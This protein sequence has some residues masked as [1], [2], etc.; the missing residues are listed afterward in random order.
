M[1]LRASKEDL[2]HTVQWNK[3]ERANA[4]NLEVDYNSDTFQDTF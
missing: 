2:R 1:K 3:K 4:L